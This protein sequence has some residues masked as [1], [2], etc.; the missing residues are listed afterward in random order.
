MTTPTTPD[1]AR[2][3]A[4][5]LDFDV[6]VSDVPGMLLSLAQ[7]VEALTADIAAEKLF[8]S[9][10]MESVTEI[11]AQ[12]DALKPGAE[13]LYRQAEAL[14]TGDEWQAFDKAATV[15]REAC[16]KVCD[17]FDTG[18]RLT[19]DFKAAEIAAAIR[20]RGHQTGAVS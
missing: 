11:A 6:Y 9:Q 16:A 17:G 14:L 18:R 3:A 1:Q 5:N 20:A 15:E 19:S 12:R 2:C 10:A 13:A 8:S 4:I 7:Q